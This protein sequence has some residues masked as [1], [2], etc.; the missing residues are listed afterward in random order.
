MHGTYETIK[1]RPVLRFERMLPHPVDAVWRAVTEPD[2]LAYWFPTA[3][4]VD[5]RPGGRM[6][7]T[8]PGDEYPPLQGEVI[9]FDPPRRFV[10]T[11]GDDQLSFELEPGADGVSCVLRLTVALD[12]PDKAARDAAGWH[13]CLG[14]LETRLAGAPVARPGTMPTEQWREYYEE[15]IR[16][17]LPAEAPVPGAGDAT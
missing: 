10:F 1:E 8:F 7:F 11:W 17:G 15:Y 3:V 12:S 5:L 9:E 16:R 13:V 14:E 6:S 4:E 2:E